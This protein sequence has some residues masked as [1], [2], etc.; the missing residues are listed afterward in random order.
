MAI[1]RCSEGFHLYDDSKHNN[2]PYCR[3]AGNVSPGNYPPTRPA[4]LP[5]GGKVRVNPPTQSA[6]AQASGVTQSA[7]N[8][9]DNRGGTIDPVVGWL[10]CIGGPNLGRDH[11]IHAGLNRIGR[12][13]TNEICIS[14]DSKISREKQATLAFD[15]EHR[16]FYLQH[17]GGRNLTYVNNKPA[18]EMMQLNSGDRI[19]MG[20]SLLLFVPLCGEEFQ[21]SEVIG[22]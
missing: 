18:L 17:G 7:W 9:E 8:L 6:G 19:K 21:W 12:D 22:E 16:F 10:V 2:C 14:E 13:H 15:P 11:R 1:I 4:S 3:N 20:E 5:E